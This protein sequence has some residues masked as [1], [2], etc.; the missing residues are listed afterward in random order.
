MSGIVYIFCEYEDL[1]FFVYFLELV[2]NFDEIF[3]GEWEECVRIDK[4]F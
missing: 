3:K 2:G 1:I 4:N